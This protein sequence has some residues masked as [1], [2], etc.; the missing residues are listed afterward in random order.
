MPKP[1]E[2]ARMTTLAI[3]GFELP[4]TRDPQV[5]QRFRRI[6][7]RTALVA[8]LLCLIMPWLP[9]PERDASEPPEVPERFARLMIE[10]TPPP[11]PPV[12][13]Q[14]PEP[15]PVVEEAAAPQPE[16]VQTPQPRPAEPPPPSA[17]ERAASAG[18]MAFADTLADLRAHE[19]VA[20]ATTAD[21]L[22]AGAGEAQFN[23]RNVVTARGGRASGGINT[24]GMS[25][26]TGG[27]GLGGRAVTQVASPGGGGGGGGG[28]GGSASG[29]GGDG[30]NARSREEIELVFD[31]NKAAI[32]ALYNRALRSDPTLR[33]RL[34]LE[35]TIAPS[36]EVTDCK[37]VSSELSDPEFERRL[38]SRVMMFRFEDK[39]VATVTT[40]KPIEF[41][42][43]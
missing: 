35:L 24:A 21:G 6:L 13:A 30:L 2:E 17:R 39:D 18:V 7:G 40:T 25:R 5:E 19:A 15:E 31:K 4:W 22:E 41:F 3:S 34:V 36:G 9:L 33:G 14:E 20:A 16:P 26:N 28:R 23:E 42:P 8:L 32:Y 27:T 43:A 1:H 38:V 37:I 12:V 29:T 10:R 11:P